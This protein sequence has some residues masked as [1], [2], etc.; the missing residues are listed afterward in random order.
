MNGQ[1][2]NLEE[3]ASEF[4]VNIYSEETHTDISLAQQDASKSLKPQSLTI[5]GLNDNSDDLS[6]VQVDHNLNNSKLT[7]H[8]NM[9]SPTIITNMDLLTSTMTDSVSS[10]SKISKHSKG[11][12]GSNKLKPAGDTISSL[13][14]ISSINLSHG[15]VSTQSNKGHI[16]TS[17]DKAVKKV[18]NF[19][20]FTGKN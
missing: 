12:P 11:F 16:K 10:S 9:T 5:S 17:L 14:N 8:L 7:N 20:T 3:L 6:I 19:D 18:H 15:E 13:S 1:L 2:A 4:D